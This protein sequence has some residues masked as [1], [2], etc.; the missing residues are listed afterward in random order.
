MQKADVEEYGWTAVPRNRS[1]VPDA[2][3]CEATT[4]PITV[5]FE[6]IWPQTEVVKK[7]EEWVKARLPEKTF[8]HSL[9]VYCYG[10]IV[11]AP[12]IPLSSQSPNTTLPSQATQ[13]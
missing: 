7:A 6:K 9:R 13:S 11:P 5:D 1:T 4:L 2:E 3:H 8:N 10:T 12:P